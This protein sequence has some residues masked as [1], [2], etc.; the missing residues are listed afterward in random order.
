MDQKKRIEILFYIILIVALFAP[1]AAALDSFATLDEPYWL[2][3]GANFYYALGQREFQNT[4]Y[5]YQ[6]A[7]T[8]CGSSQLP[9]CFI[10]QNIA[11]WDR[12]TLSL[13]KGCLTLLCLNRA[14]PRLCFCAMRA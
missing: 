6:P 13:K 4:V 9:C 7:V 14:S 1:R 5:E 3:M 12:G 8:T 11:V 10:F 2:S